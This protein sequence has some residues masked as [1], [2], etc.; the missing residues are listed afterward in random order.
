MMRNPRSAGSP[1]FTLVELL[2]VVAIIG[3][4][5]GI[6]IPAVQQAREA[7]NR[8]QCTNNL[9]Q[10]GLAFHNYA[11]R[12]KVFPCGFTNPST[13]DEVSWM[14]RI[15]PDIEQDAL[16]S[17]YDFTKDFDDPVNQP[18]AGTIIPG[19]TCPS[20]PGTSPRFDTTPSDVL[21]TT[22]PR[23]CTDY[24][25]VNAIKTFVYA[26][27]FPTNL[28]APTNKNDPRVVGAITRINPT[29]ITDVVDGLSSTIMIAEDAGRPQN[30]LPGFRPSLTK[31]I[32]KEGGWVDPNAAFS[33]DGSDPGTGVVQTV[34]SASACA[35]NCA[36]DSEVY[37]FHPGGA[38][39]VWCDGSVHFINK[40]VPLCVL[41]CLVTRS[42][43]DRDGGFMAQFGP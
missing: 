7:A 36:N 31:P 41:A 27:C 42:N 9:K 34:F 33:I 32:T 13:T 16:Y 25:S 30:Y 38:N 2:V 37:A 24:S 8:T 21:G 19:Y 11:D 17:R 3:V 23:A 12:Y 5:V 26:G 20:T 15:L 14:V 35:V 22:G 4:L 1:G 29:R 43:G 39:A 18:V 40:S 28:P 10:I 6:L